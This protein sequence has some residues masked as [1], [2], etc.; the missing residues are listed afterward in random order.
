[1]MSTSTTKPAP[2]T[3]STE[4]SQYSRF[5]L[6][7]L[8]K[9]NSSQDKMAEKIERLQETINQTLSSLR[10]DVNA[11]EN[12]CG[13]CNPS[14][15]IRIQM[16]TSNLKD[17]QKDQE[18]RLRKLEISTTSFGGKWTV[19]SAIGAIVLSALISMLFSSAKA[20]STP[21]TNDLAQQPT[22]SSPANP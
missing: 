19:I 8:E 13:R 2:M 12:K 21:S 4:W 17:E 1:M 10:T 22:I 11:L 14:D 7:Q 16:D 6:S 20:E 3:E 5:V 9:L 18:E 15:L